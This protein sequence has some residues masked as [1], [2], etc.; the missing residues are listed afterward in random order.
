ME[1]AVRSLR[2]LGDMA[3]EADVRVSVYNH[4]DCWSERVAFCV[5]VVKKAHHPRVGFNFN[6]CHWLDYR[7]EL[8]V[9][10]NYV[11]H[12]RCRRRDR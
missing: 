5:E 8:A 12:R 10:R 7:R 3:A 4:V 6:L 11:V 9:A 1:A 2:E